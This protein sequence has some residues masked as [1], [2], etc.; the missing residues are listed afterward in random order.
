MKS[1][2][3]IAAACILAITWLAHTSASAQFATSLV[4]PKTNYLSYEPIPGTV[5]ITNRSGGDIVMTGRGESNWLS[6]DVTDG[7]GRSLP[8]IGIAQE[9][10]FIFKAGSSIAEKVMLSSHYSLT[11]LGSYAVTATIFHPPTQ[12]YY[13]SNRVR[14]N[15]MDAKAFWEQPIGV[16]AGYPEAGRIRRYALVNFRDVDRSNLYFRLLDDK[17][18]QTLA[19]FELGP[20]SISTEPQPILDHENTLHV[21][22][23]ALPKLH[24]YSILSPDGKLKKREYYKTVEENRPSLVSAPDGSVSVRGGVYFDPQAP[25]PA[26]KNSRP[27]SERPPGL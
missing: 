18:K 26:K 8:S 24:C 5:T 15:V 1:P 21:L 16:P 6:F 9:K 4:L 25:E 19:T 13:T 17:S 2:S 20:V 22:F 27:I 12:Q 14:F 10:P 11:D 23:L 3:I 7:T